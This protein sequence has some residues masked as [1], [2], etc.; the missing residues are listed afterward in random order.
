MQFIFKPKQSKTYRARYT[1]GDDPRVYDVSL[2]TQNKEE[3]ALKLRTL[4]IEAEQEKK[5]IIAPRQIRETASRPVQE[6][7]SEYVADLHQ[8]GRDN[9]Y[10]DKVRSRLPILFEACHWA[11][12]GRIKAQ[13]FL[14]WR[15]EQTFAPKTL[16]HYLDT[17]R[18][19]LNW[20]VKQELLEKNP[21]LHL[22]KVDNRLREQAEP[23]AFTPDEI[24]RLL[25]V[26][27]RNEFAYL[28]MLCTG[29]RV[30]EANSPLKKSALR[31]G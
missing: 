6:L 14:G 25:A 20:L 28:L 27:G 2:K 23:R 10:I 8:R 24:G 31:A 13:D 17:A 12:V 21:L 5:G 26:S 22:D 7:F 4:L 29:L 11:N 1:V 18:G 19:F 9:E 16:N 15:R 3:A 30:T